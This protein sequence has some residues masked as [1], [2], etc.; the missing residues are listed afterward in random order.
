MILNLYIEVC[1]WMQFHYMHNNLINKINSISLQKT[2]PSLLRTISVENM[3][4]LGV[5]NMTCQHATAIADIVQNY[6]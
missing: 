5:L 4:S 6:Q 2:S 1:V 3:F